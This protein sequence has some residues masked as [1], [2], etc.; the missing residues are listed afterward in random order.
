MSATVVAAVSATVPAEVEV[1]VPAAMSAAQPGAV[2]A[3]ISSSTSSSYS[4][5]SSESSRP[6]TKL[7]DLGVSDEGVRSFLATLDQIQICRPL[8]SSAQSLK[9]LDIDPLI[10]T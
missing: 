6:S 8:G 10:P 1:A 2:L 7:M 9:H 4:S 5:S 3:W